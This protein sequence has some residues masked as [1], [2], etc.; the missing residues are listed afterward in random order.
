MSDE[1]IYPVRLYG[2]SISYFTGKME[3]YFR[4][5]GIP[6]Q[7]LPISFPKKANQIKEKVGCSQMPAVELADGRWMTDSTEMIQWFD[8]QNNTLNIIPTHPIIR[9]FSLLL[10]DYADEWLW[11]PAM[12][13]RWHYPVGAHF[14]GTHLAHEVA[15]EIRAP[16]F[17]KRLNI[18]HRQR[19]GFTTG[20]GISKSEIPKIEAIYLR[21]LDHLQ[22]IFEAQ[23]F[24][25]GT[26][27]SLADVAFAG[28]FVRHFGLDPVPAEIMRQS[29][30]AVYEWI[31]RLWN[32][33]PLNS[34]I[35]VSQTPES[36]FPLFADIGKA[37]LPYLNANLNAVL[38][39]KARFDCRIDG[40]NYKRARC[41]HYR[42]RCLIQLRDQFKKLTTEEQ[43]AAE[44]IL[45]LSKCWDPL[46]QSSDDQ[47][48]D[49]LN[50]GNSLPFF[51]DTTMLDVY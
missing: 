1:A 36:W 50:L 17:L 48:K 45:K 23:P 10:E 24:L 8:A 32:A 14:A 41:S 31:A 29:A 3:T 38:D 39:G 20:D 47:L 11:R 19:K 7:L 4:L 49:F 12:H 28:P 30:P 37:Y 18:T 5:M 9:F 21:T 44:E 13:Y 40:V 16:V 26:Q 34:E 51:A 33:G 6:Y 25:L 35:S 27:P 42:V 15:A 46:W 22:R 2:S 43:S